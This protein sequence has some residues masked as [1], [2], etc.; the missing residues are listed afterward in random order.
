VTRI[1]L[2][3]DFGDERQI[4]PG[5]IRL[6]ELVRDTG[7][8]SAAGRALDMSYRRAWLLIDDLNASF[9]EPV[10]TTTLG[11]KGGGGAVLS[12]F[13]LELIARYREM[14]RMA[15]QALAEH[16]APLE[17]ELA[18]AEPASEAS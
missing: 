3:L 9:R 4:G 18:P 11:G 16:L 5:K 7:S 17:A 12:P 15:A 2:R 13:G 8:I 1:F 6:L 10:L 14:E